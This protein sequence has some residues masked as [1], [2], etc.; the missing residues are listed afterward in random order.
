MEISLVLECFQ[1]EKPVTDEN[2]QGVI[3]ELE[4]MILPYTFKEHNLKK[5]F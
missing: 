3:S 5:N 2:P 4:N 1:Q